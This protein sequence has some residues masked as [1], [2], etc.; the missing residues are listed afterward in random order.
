[1]SFSY[2]Y[3]VQFR[4]TDAAGVVYFASILS[5][6]HIAYEAA[7]IR[8]GIDL[9]SFVSDPDFG[10]PIYHVSADFFKPLFCGDRITID[11][12]P[13]QIDNYRFE[14]KYQIFSTED[15]ESDLDN[16]S[17]SA[18]A[19]TKHVTIDPQMR[20]RRE[21]PEQLVKWILQWT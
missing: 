21:L 3:T 7:L 18:T 9:K 15:V 20:K 13:C 16:R 5:I 19:I 6:C 8:S 10:V 14:I 17:I 11:L 1:M 12:I 4:D 2:E